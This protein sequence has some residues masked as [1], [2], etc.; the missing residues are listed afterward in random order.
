MECILRI[1]SDTP[2]LTYMLQLDDRSLLHISMVIRE[3]L[4][5]RELD[6]VSNQI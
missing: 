4:L 2:C 3:L 5:Y 6:E 1:L